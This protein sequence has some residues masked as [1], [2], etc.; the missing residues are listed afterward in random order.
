MMYQSSSHFIGLHNH[1]VI[2]RKNMKTTK[3]VTVAVLAILGASAVWAAPEDLVYFED[4][5]LR[6]AVETTLGK[7]D[8]NEADMLLLMSLHA[9][10]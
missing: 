8:P 1:N 6:Y 7:S 9:E 10:G 5:H 3:L 2:R 4:S